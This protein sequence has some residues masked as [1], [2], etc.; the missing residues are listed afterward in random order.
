MTGE[1][2]KLFRDFLDGMLLENKEDRSRAPRHSERNS[3][4][5]FRRD[6]LRCSGPRIR[7]AG[8]PSA[9][10]FRAGNGG[11]GPALSRRRFVDFYETWYTPARAT[12]VAAGKFDVPMVERLIRRQFQDAK[13]RRGEQPDPSFGKVSLGRGTIA[14]LHS[15]ADANSVSLSLS[16]VNPASN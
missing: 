15:D 9:P 6:S 1:A 11:N 14:G 2:L 4:Q 7:V 10:P 8:D 3:G 16:V 5:Q 13:A 12:I